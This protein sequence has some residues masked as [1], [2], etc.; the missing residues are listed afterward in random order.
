[1]IT[2]AAVKIYDCRQQKE[3]IIPC[4]RHADALE[5]LYELGYKKN[6][7]YKKLAEGFL[8]DDGLF[9]SHME[10]YHEA[11]ESKQLFVTFDKP[12][13]LYSEDLW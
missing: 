9:L 4:M 7:D 10:A 3:I 13:E 1:M 2:R 8:T 5:I 12:R 11:V 6:V